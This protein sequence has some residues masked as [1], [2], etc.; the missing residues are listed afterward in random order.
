MKYGTKSGAVSIFAL[1]KNVEI[2]KVL[3]M[4]KRVIW[5]RLTTKLT[6]CVLND[7][8]L[9]AGHDGHRRERRS[10]IDADDV[11]ARGSGERALLLREEARL[12]P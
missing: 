8:R 6:L 4:E 7:L 2:V 1:Q 9:L 12:A 11:G 3:K 5:F 10:Q